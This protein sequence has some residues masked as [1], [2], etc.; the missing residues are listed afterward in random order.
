MLPALTFMN[1]LWQ[2]SVVG[3]KIRKQKKSQGQQ[4]NFAD[5]SSPALYNY[6]Y[7]IIF[8]QNIWVF[9]NVLPSCNNPVFLGGSLEH[10]FKGILR[11]TLWSFWQPFRDIICQKRCHSCNLEIIKVALM[12]EWPLRIWVWVHKKPSKLDFQ[13]CYNN[14]VSYLSSTNHFW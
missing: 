8:A 4:S 7:N 11:P 9:C 14:F 5:Q 13:F 3:I 12:L 6:I 2:E 1:I 10:R